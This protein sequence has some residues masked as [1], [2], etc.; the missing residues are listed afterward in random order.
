MVRR[1]ASGKLGE[2]AK[3]VELEFVKADLVSLFNNLANDEQDSVRLLA[4]EGCSSIASV[5]PDE[6][7][8]SLLMPT[9]RAAAQVARTLVYPIENKEN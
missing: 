4:V 8:E 2:F 7:K 6:D 9:V 1:A 5:L 3:C